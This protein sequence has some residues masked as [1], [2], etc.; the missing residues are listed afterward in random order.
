MQVPS[1]PWPAS[2]PFALPESSYGP[3]T[4]QGLRRSCSSVSREDSRFT[5]LGSESAKAMPGCCDKTSELAESPI[6]GG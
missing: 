4:F 1:P 6:T 3:R 5:P 2:C